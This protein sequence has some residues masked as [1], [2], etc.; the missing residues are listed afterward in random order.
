M[1]AF[2]CLMQPQRATN[3]NIRLAEYVPFGRAPGIIYVT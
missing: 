1:G 2:N 3:L